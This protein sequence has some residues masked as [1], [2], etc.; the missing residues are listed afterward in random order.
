M[1]TTEVNLDLQSDREVTEPRFKDRIVL[2]DES[3]I[4]ATNVDW[5]EPAT[6]DRTVT[7]PDPTLDTEFVLR[8]TQQTLTNKKYS[9]PIAAADDLVNKNYVDT[10]AGGLPDATSAPGGGTKGK[11]TFDSDLGLDV[12]AGVAAVKVDGASISFDGS[13]QLQTV[14]PPLT[15]EESDLAPSVPNVSTMRFPPGSVTDL[16]G[17]IVSIANTAPGVTGALIYDIPLTRTISGVAPPAPGFVGTDFDILDY[18]KALGTTGVRF[19]FTVPDDYASGNLELLVVYRMSSAVAAPNNVIRVSTQMKIASVTTGLIDVAS[20]PETQA[21][22]TVPDNSTGIVRQGILTITAGDFGVGDQLQGYIKRFAGSGNDLHTGDWQVIGFQVRYV[23]SIG[24]RV[25]YQ[26][27]PFVENA[28]G[29]TPPT[30]GTIGTDIDVQVLPTGADAGAKMFFVVPDN[31]DGVSDMLF[32]L[33]YAMSTAA[34]GT[35]RLDVYGEVASVMTGAITPIPSQFFDLVPPVDTGVHRTVSIRSLAPT[36]LTPG[37]YICLTIVRRVGV[38]GNHTGD[39]QM[40]TAYST[41]GA[42]VSTTTGTD[43]TERYIDGPVFGNPSGPG[44]FGDMDYPAFGGDFDALVSLASTVAAGE[45]DVS[46]HGRLA[47]TQTRITSIRVSIKG[48]GASPNYRLLVYAE[49]S[50]AVPVYDSGLVAAPGVLTETILTDLDLSA[51][52][53]GQRRFHVVVHAEID[54]S[55]AVYCSRPFVR[56]ES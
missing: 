4:R 43:T 52:P 55:E 28:V 8:D 50:G 22:F 10:V 33:D 38:G 14:V 1:A 16:G 7:V 9:G 44:V 45:L 12:V 11:V 39:F 17:G 35:V 51:Q 56:Q 53:T 36:G 40:L 13:G 21:D 25:V 54:A 18:Q 3:A 42:G 26:R 48:G 30:P 29:V 46:F 2:R 6:A 27:I 41:F 20:Y 32:R 23:G 49:G 37:D 15:V 5:V 34:V 47:S 31:W 24:N 19:E